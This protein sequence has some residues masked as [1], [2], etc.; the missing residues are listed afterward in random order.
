VGN[1]TS[2]EPRPI[3]NSSIFGGISTWKLTEVECSDLDSADLLIVQSQEKLREH[4]KSCTP[5]QPSIKT[6][7]NNTLVS[8]SGEN[9][10]LKISIQKYLIEY[11]H[12]FYFNVIY[13]FIF[14]TEFS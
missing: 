1:K 5:S 12:V 3:P 7:E 14:F 9:N 6:I 10:N 2:L 4:S 13:F 8:S 11:H